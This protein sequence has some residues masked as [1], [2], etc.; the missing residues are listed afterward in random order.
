MSVPKINA[1]I[2]GLIEDQVLY[3][4]EDTNQIDSV[5]VKDF[6]EDEA[7]HKYIETDGVRVCMN[8]IEVTGRGLI[9][10]CKGYVYDLKRSRVKSQISSEAMRATREAKKA[11]LDEQK[12]LAKEAKE[13]QKRIEKEKKEEEKRK[14]KE[15]REAAKAAKEATKVS[16]KKTSVFEGKKVKKSV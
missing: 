7:G 15:E 13:E 16:N 14:A 2:I 6:R 10:A 8:E 12:R 3:I 1:F 11:Q 5:E 9:S 4:R